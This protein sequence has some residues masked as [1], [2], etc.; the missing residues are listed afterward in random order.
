MYP[1]SDGGKGI[2]SSLAASCIFGLLY[3]YVT[4]LSPL[5]A[6]EVY[7]WRMLL[8]L[9]FL[10]AL[11]IWTGY[12]ELVR[13]VAR[14]IRRNKKM[15][16]LLALSSFLV[17]VQFWLFMWAPINGKALQL[18][19]G[20]LLM[21]LSM[22]VC[23]RIFYR[24]VLRPHQKAAVLCALVGVTNQVWQVGSVSREALVVALGFPA[25]FLLR[26]Y[27]HTDNLGGLWFDILFM[28]PV[29]ALAVY[30]GP[31]GLQA[32]AE[33]PA[34]GVFVP[35]LGLLSAVAFLLYILAS[36][37]LPLG[38]FGLLSYVEPVLLVMVSLLLGEQITLKEMPTYGFIGIA[39]IILAIG[40][41]REQRHARRARP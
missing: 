15:L 39:M 19:L 36:K 40:G 4:V 25:Y 29:A 32:F 1:L 28:T 8:T 13:G 12:W 20:Y 11:M 18:S 21:P 37:F 5:D 7:G 31:A 23:G 30:D 35:A 24:E 6:L 14:A 17:G 10:T 26:R 16:L 41:M 27:L 38:L 34:L 2:V 9:P 33:R 22:V 3:F